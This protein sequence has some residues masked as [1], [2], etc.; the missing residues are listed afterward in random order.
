MKK[1]VAEL[2]KL[3]ALLI[4]LLITGSFIQ[5]PKN[6]I[7]NPGF[8][9]GEGKNPA[10]WKITIP[11]NSNSCEAGIDDKEF[12][13]G[14]QSYKISGIWTY[15]RR[16]IYLKTEKP[17]PVNPQKKYLLNFWYKT[18]GITEYPESFSAQFTVE[19]DNTPTV[20]YDKKIYNS[21]QWQQY[22]ILLDN[23]P[24]DAKQL[25]LSFGFNI[26]T[27]GSIWLD[28]VEF[29]EATKPDIDE[30]EQWRRQ[31]VPEVVGKTGNKSFNASNYFRVEKAD[32]RW[33]IIDPYGIPTWG[34]SIAGTRG[35]MPDC[36]NPA[37]SILSFFGEY[38]TTSSGI[39][40]KLYSFFMDDCGFNSFAGWS[41][42]EY[43]QISK[44]RFKS[45]KPY[46][47][48]TRVL[49]LSSASNDSNVFAKDRDGNLLNRSGHEVVDPFNPEWRKLAKEKAERLIS[50]YR[51]EPSFLGWFVDNEMSFDELF[52]YIW[53]EY[54]SKEFISSLEKKYKSIDNL[55]QAWTS[56]FNRYQY[57]TFSDI[58][59]DK[60]EP[61]EW[62]DPV[63]ID[64]A[65]FERLMMKEYI[66][67]TYNL[68]KELDPNH[69]VISNRINLGPMPDIHR[70]ID[71][72]GKYDIVCMNIY[73]DNNKIGFNPGELE[74][75]RKLHQGTGRPIIIGEWSIPAIDSKLYEFGQ[76]PYKRQLDWSWPQVLRTQ[77]ERGEAYE[78]CIKQLASLD[79]MIGAG[80]FIT[81]DVDTPERRANRG[82]L[83]KNYELYHELTNAMKKAHDDIKNA[84][85]LKW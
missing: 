72:W 64:F 65:A 15:P 8:E 47:P 3:S 13:S 23:M 83:N 21:N 24:P 39:N 9:T 37:E 80:W 20:R 12:H 84:M 25:T 4:S 5:H 58:L 81:F 70:T 46:M 73:P 28:D 11:S 1:F 7:Q 62:N 69:L 14:R 30:F 74:I 31:P 32:D 40:E 38:G 60:P 63:W 2:L 36:N 35:R 59:A 27:K 76:D 75:M 78:I 29:R 67:F 57:L 18:E 22:F 68:V 34:I 6:L 77:K 54:S 49:G 71:L 52:R 66:D 55:N 61:K 45:G 82:I 85:E 33:W 10:D 42:D 26:T 43:A 48:I 79:F 16:S 56:R 50:V 17:I 19:C 51:G 44:E 41:A 53:A